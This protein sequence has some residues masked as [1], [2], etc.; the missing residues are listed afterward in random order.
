MPQ[1]Q[2]GRLEKA[3]V[4]LNEKVATWTKI[5]GIFTAVLAVATIAL[6]GFTLW[7]SYTAYRVAIDTRE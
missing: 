3:Q 4:E 5:V 1:D 2:R 7:Q 6:C